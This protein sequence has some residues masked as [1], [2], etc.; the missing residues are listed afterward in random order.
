MPFEFAT[1]PEVTR[2]LPRFTGLESRAAW[3]REFRGF[4]TDDT[5]M[6]MCH[7]R[8]LVRC[9][10]LDPEDTA[11][12]FVAWFDTGDH[13]GIGFTCNG[14]L[15]KLIAG[16]PWD[17][18]GKTGPTAAGN[19][20]AMKI[21]PVALAGARDLER[22]HEDCRVAT[23]ITHNCEEAFAGARAVAHAVALAARRE[24]D[25]ATLIARTIAWIGPSRT[26]ER[27]ARAGRLLAESARPADAL[28]EIKCGGYVVETVGAS[29]YCF[30]HDPDDPELAIV[31]AVQG[32]FDADTTGAV[33]GA[34]AGAYAG[35][36]ALPAAWVDRLEATDRI[37]A[38][39]DGLLAVATAAAP[40]A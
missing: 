17:R 32:G 30:L 26:A 31:T 10:R 19:G 1:P 23:L 20:A 9:G 21:A 33:T 16:V 2:Y 5:H 35:A 25:P 36:S 39:A 34:I 18:S 12:E 3:A 13:R 27:L 7:A 38:L 29:F 6:T 22:L 4:W 37:A 40:A 15:R 8:S 11:R 14:A 24:L 28:L